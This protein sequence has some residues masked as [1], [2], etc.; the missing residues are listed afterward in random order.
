MAITPPRRPPL[1]FEA[2]CQ[3]HQRPYLLYAQ[4]RSGSEGCARSTVERA[5]DELSLRWRTALQS[6]C[7]PARAWELLSEAAAVHDPCR[8]ERRWCTTAYDLLPDEQADVIVLR[9]G[10]N[11]N[12]GQ[13][14]TLMGAD[15]SAVRIRLRAAE[16][17]LRR[18]R[19]K[20]RTSPFLSL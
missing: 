6:P 1:E 8:Q 9:H 12:V 10:V 14:A 2:F 5:L 17:A 19:P 16:A 15:P 20:M 13:M 18:R 4:A 11:L 7:L 3:L